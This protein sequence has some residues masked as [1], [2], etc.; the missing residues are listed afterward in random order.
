MFV[1]LL[2]VLEDQAS[3]KSVSPVYETRVL[4]F[5]FPFPLSIRPWLDA[6]I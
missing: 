6:S 3:L 4:A 5:G 1:F 2:S